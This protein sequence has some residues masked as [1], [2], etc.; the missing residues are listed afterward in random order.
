MVARM[1]DFLTNMQGYLDG[2]YDP[3]VSSQ[4]SQ[5]VDEELNKQELQDFIYGQN[6]F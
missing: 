1:N 4:D 5:F 2:S 3:N 6:R